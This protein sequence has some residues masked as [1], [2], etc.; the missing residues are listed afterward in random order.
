MDIRIANE[1]DWEGIIEIYNQA[2]KTGVSTADITPV[3][4]ESKSDW[5]KEHSEDKYVIYIEEEEGK[6]IGWCSISPYRLGRMALRYTAEISYYIAENQRK[7]G[8]AT[9]LIQYAIDDCERL[10]IKTLFGILLDTNGA[11]IKLL[12]KFG[13]ENWGHMPRVA[14]FDGNECGHLYMGKR[15]K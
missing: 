5:L 12:E 9:R 4:V 13:F 11:S 14:D 6:I 7:R 10:E 1:Q 2:I 8:V 15:I 3:T